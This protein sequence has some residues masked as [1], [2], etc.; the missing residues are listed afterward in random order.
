MKTDLY[1]AQA[2]LDVCHSCFS[3]HRRKSSPASSE[4]SNADF[5]SGPV[6]VKCGSSGGGPEAAAAAR[7]RAGGPHSCHTALTWRRTGEQRSCGLTWY[8]RDPDPAVWQPRLMRTHTGIW[9]MTQRE[10]DLIQR[11]V[12]FWQ[13]RGS[14]VSSRIVVFSSY[15]SC[16]CLGCNTKPD[17]SLYKHW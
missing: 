2:K 13:I 8:C 9:I 6:W 4:N 1:S 5:Q 16:G 17:P 14:N 12:L 3:P 10:D 11:R 15:N 7:K